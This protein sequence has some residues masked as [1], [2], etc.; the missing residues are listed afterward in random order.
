M[1]LVAG[2]GDSDDPEADSDAAGSAT[3]QTAPGPTQQETLSAAGVKTIQ[4]ARDEVSA[5]CR[6]VD[7]GLSGGPG[8]TP[9]DLD[10]VNAALDELAQVAAE[11]PG[12]EMVDGT[13]PRLALGDI[14]ENL[15]GTNCDPRLVAQIDEALAT[16]PAD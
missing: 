15:E 1:A 5:Y 6:K 10:R 8:P 13:T 12:A 2:C 9:A 3:T 4:R 7:Q 14:A 11:Q 16:L